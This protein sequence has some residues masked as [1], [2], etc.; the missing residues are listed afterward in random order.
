M[1]LF[2]H[3]QRIFLFLHFR[4]RFQ[5]VLIHLFGLFLHVS[6]VQI[7]NEPHPTITRF[8][9]LEVYYTLGLSHVVSALP[10]AQTRF[11]R[12]AVIEV[13]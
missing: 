12:H 4:L 9:V 7:L 10:L 1:N 11:W 13:T 5:W 8:V 2:F 3:R 6:S